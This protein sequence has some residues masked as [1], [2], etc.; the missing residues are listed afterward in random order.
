MSSPKIVTAVRSCVSR[1][2][3][4]GL[5]GAVR[6]AG[7]ESLVRAW[8]KLHPIERVAAFRALS[9]F[10]AAEV[11]SA[12]PADG[13]WLAYLAEVSEGAAPLLEGASASAVRLLR[14]ASARERAAMRKALG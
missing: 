1:R 8:P 13:K 5:A 3:I 10:A 9:P 12:L 11:F 2:D 6:A 7:P 4:R 14:R